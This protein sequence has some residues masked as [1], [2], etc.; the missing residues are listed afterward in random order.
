MLDINI[1]AF[2]RPIHVGGVINIS[3]CNAIEIHSRTI[4]SFSDHICVIDRF[5]HI[6]TDIHNKLT[7]FNLNMTT[8]LTINCLAIK[9]LLIWPVEIEIHSWN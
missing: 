6:S 3:S 9:Q 5:L 1:V 8:W 2:G 7:L 4:R